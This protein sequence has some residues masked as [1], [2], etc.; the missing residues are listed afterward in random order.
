[1]KDQKGSLI[2]E[3]RGRRWA[4]FILHP[5]TFILAA[6]AWLFLAG[7][8]ER[9]LYSSHE[10]RAAQNADSLLEP[11]SDGVPRLLDDSPETQKP[12]LYYWL[13]ALPRLMGCSPEWAVRLPAALSGLG[14]I[15]LLLIGAANLGRP[16]AGLIAAGVLL[17]SIHYPWL[18]RIG[19]ID[20]P[21][22]FAVT[23]AS[24]AFIFALRGER[25]WLIVGWLGCAIGVLL[26][27][28]IGLALPAA[29]VAAILLAEGRWP[30]FWEWREWRSLLHELGVWW[31]VPLVLLV[32]VPVFAWLH[33]RTGG[34]FTYDFFY[35]HNVQRGLGGSRLREH[36]WWLYGPYLLLYLLPAS[37]L[38][39]C[40]LWPRLWRHDALARAGLAWMCGS[41]ALLSAA[42]FKRAD[43]LLPVY[44]GAALFLGCL[45]DRWASFRPRLVL[46]PCVA[47]L[48][49]AL[50][51]WA[52]YLHVQLPAE[53]AYRDYRPLAGLIKAEGGRVV[54]FRAE[55]HA[56]RYRVGRHSPVLVEWRGLREE[57][58]GAG[59]TLVVMPPGAA[60][61][62]ERQLPGVRLE[63]VS[64]TRELAGGRHERP[65]LLLR[66][67]RPL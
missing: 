63:P 38:L 11:D 62:A 30:A 8:G 23:G 37:P 58:S 14:V 17:A 40:A 66:A 47:A 6:A 59:P 26:K 50:I 3:G 22:A 32:C 34:A 53:R 29:I 31:G 2:G 13:A 20:M 39:L 64:G 12:P 21:L 5:S 4:P 51:S 10:A 56:L 67:S 42:K 25:R 48:I 41:L 55:A 18:A 9:E 33:A 7:L 54:F 45:L 27:G 16:T 35:F 36:A 49:C 65:L 52:A 57:L 60:A 28:P 19:R 44:P 46:G 1:M 43:Y 61:E 24:L 15:A